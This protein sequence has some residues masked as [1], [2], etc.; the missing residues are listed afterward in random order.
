[1]NI[2]PRHRRS[3]DKSNR[4]MLGMCYFYRFQNNVIKTRMSSGHSQYIGHRCAFFVNLVF[5][6]TKFGRENEKYCLE[7]GAL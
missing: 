1:M 3:M 6:S 7:K 4:F 5:L 2:V